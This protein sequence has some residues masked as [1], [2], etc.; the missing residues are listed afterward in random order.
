MGLDIRPDEISSILKKQ[1]ENFATDADVYD[2]GTVLQVGDGIARIHGL[3]NVMAGELVSFP[4]D[5]MGIGG[6]RGPVPPH[7]HLLACLAGE[8][9]LHGAMA[10]DG[11][12]LGARAEAAHLRA[13]RRHRRR[14]DHEPA[15]GSGRGAEL[16]LPLYLD[17]GLRVHRLRL[18]PARIHRRGGELRRLSLRAVQGT[19]GRR[20]A[21]DHV[22][23]RRAAR[24]RRGNARSPRRLP[25][26][27]AGADRQRRL[28]S[29][30]ARH[31]RRA[32]GLGLPLQQATARRSRTTCGA[33]TCVA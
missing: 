27:E 2:V 28:R 13:H 29:A 33:R 20:R 17:P 15:R 26:V 16:G 32:D 19:V 7:R 14:A 30:P 23:H 6:G 8:V 21:A 1:L 4:N 9:Q 22:R 10:R 5:V 3:T 31:L 18:P 24:A 12:P 11:P 25:G